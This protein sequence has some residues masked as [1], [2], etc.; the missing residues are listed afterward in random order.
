MRYGFRDREQN[1][2]VPEYITHMVTPS[3]TLM[4]VCISTHSVSAGKQKGILFGEGF[5]VKPT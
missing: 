2:L 1:D 5:T 3:H 4:L